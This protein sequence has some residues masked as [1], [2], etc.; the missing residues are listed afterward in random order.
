MLQQTPQ[1]PHLTQLPQLTIPPAEI[2]PAHPAPETIPLT[3][4]H[5]G[6]ETYGMRD[7]AFIVQKR[8]ILI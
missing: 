4:E 5:T 6:K 2:M 1:L 3:Q 8:K 7:N